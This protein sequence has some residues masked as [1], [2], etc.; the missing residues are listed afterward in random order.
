M[1]LSESF[2]RKIYRK[3]HTIIVYY[4]WHV[5]IDEIP[6]TKVIN[7]VGYSTTFE[8]FYWFIKLP[9]YTATT[10]THFK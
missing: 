3:G 9:G 4:M 1:A 8:I 7:W 5:Q 10:R 6:N 2:A